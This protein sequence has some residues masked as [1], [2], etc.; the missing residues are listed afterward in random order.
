MSI[1]YHVD[2]KMGVTFVSWNGLVSA[3]MFLNHVRRLSSDTNWPTAKRLHLSDLRTTSLDASM[4]DATLEKASRLY[5]EHPDKITDLRVAVV[6]EDAFWKA[7]AF[8][9]L[10]SK[11]RALVVVFNSLSTAC[12]WLGIDAEKADAKLKQLRG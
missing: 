12:T 2:E 1:A 6:A 7:V 5:G 4:D 8:E 11:Y 9:R 10:I 3:D